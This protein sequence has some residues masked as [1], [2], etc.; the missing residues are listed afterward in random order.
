V[1]KIT[2]LGVACGLAVLILG[3]AAFAQGRIEEAREAQRQGSE[4]H[5]KGD[6]QGALR[7]FHRAVALAPEAPLSWFNRGL[8]HRAL[9]NCPAAIDDF[10]RALVL[11]PDFFNAL[12]QRAGCLAATRTPQRALEDYTRAISI[13]GRVDAR[14]LAFYGRADVYRR[15]GRLEEADAD[16]TQVIALRTD[17]TAL[18]SRAWVNFY[19]GRWRESFQDV[20]RHLHETEGKEPDAAYSVMLGVL[21]LR[22]GGDMQQA[23]KFL[24]EWSARVK[25]AP[26]PGAILAYLESG[27]DAAL[28]LV[29]SNPAE[30]TEARAYVGSNLLALREL[31]RGVELLRQVVR[32]GDPSYLEY[33]LAYHELRRLGLVRPQDHKRWP[34]S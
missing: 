8:V 11:E 25:A 15:L 10:S 17:T 29:A 5:A 14:F 30:S 2:A 13:P 7:E 23:R 1:R 20:A 12:Y 9:K 34:R 33:D 31:P 22:R 16:Y 3:E 26:W 28:L 27:A 18:R 21:A 6:L 4:L 32:D 24:N 19:R